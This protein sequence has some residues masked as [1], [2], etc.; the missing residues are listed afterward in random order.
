MLV[1]LVIF[2]HD[3]IDKRDDDQNDKTN[4]QPCGINQ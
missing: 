2:A 1:V 4:E 3:H